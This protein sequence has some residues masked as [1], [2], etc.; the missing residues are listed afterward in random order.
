MTEAEQERAKVV[1]HLERR[2]FNIIGNAG[3]DGFKPDEAAM[4]LNSLA[5]LLFARDDIQRGDHHTE[6]NT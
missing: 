3:I 1:T 5:E 6:S 2:I 4:V